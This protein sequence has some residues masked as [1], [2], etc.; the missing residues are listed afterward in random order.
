MTEPVPAPT[1][2]SRIIT[3]DIPG[4]I[5]YRDDRCVVLRDIAPAAPVH[6]LVVPVEPIP[7]LAAT[8]VAHEA[9]LG[10]LLVIA[11]RVAAQEGIAA[12][13]YRVIVNTGV[14]GGQTVPHL[15]LHVLGGRTLGALVGGTLSHAA[16][17]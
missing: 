16:E 7:S 6:L 12:S 17:S 8:D 3:G 14:D 15:H 11:A 4:D 13:G 1:I 5:I 9:L 10:H 2:F